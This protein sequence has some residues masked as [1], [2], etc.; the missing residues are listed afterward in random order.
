V[1]IM[2]PS[3]VLDWYLGFLH[4]MLHLDGGVPMWRD[5]RLT[6]SLRYGSDQLPCE[7]GRTFTV[8]EYR[9]RFTELCSQGW[10]WINLEA[11]GLLQ[12]MLLLHV[13]PPPRTPEGTSWTSVNMKGPAVALKE[14][15]YALDDLVR[16]SEANAG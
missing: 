6:E 5:I 4:Y 16:Q 12:G 3:T 15:G 13:Q 7:V 8:D 9:V 2:K 14:R 11:V 10:S 1:E